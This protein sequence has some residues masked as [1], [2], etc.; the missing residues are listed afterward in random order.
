MNKETD[1]KF[2]NFHQ[3]S[4]LQCDSKAFLEIFKKLPISKFEKGDLVPF[5]VYNNIR[6][7]FIRNLFQ[8][9]DLYDEEFAKHLK[10]LQSAYIWNIYKQLTEEFLHKTAGMQHK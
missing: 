1:K 6:Y 2:I 10:N 9:Y 5:T 8:S 4:F 7:T 3:L